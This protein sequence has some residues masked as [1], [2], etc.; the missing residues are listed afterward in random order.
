MNDKIQEN[1][2]RARAAREAARAEEE[3]RLGRIRT[4]AENLVARATESLE[5]QECVHLE[6]FWR[7]IV[8]QASAP[9]LEFS[10]KAAL[11]LPP[12]D[13]KLLQIEALKRPDDALRE[14]MHI[15]QT[16]EGIYMSGPYLRLSP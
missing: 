1:I 11:K 4:V 15:I 8:E 3:A 13:V 12:R 7:D 16:T 14:A 10:L 6:R 9:V 2:A 5:H